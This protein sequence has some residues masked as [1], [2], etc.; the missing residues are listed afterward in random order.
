M[1]IK[2]MVYHKQLTSNSYYIKYL[3]LPFCQVIHVIQVKTLINEIERITNT[4]IYL[5]KRITG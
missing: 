4:L 5:Y 3:K 1:P 2:T